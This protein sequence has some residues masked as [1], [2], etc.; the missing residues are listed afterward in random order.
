MSNYLIT[1]LFLVFQHEITKYDLLLAYH[2]FK[3]SL[4][5]AQT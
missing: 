5:N 2:S 3:L 1:W 4:R